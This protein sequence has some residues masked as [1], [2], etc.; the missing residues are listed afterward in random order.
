[1]HSVV[2]GTGTPKDRDEVN[3]RRGPLVPRQDPDEVRKKKIDSCDMKRIG[4]TKGRNRCMV[5]PLA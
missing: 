4:H 3:R 1:M 5:A 2:R